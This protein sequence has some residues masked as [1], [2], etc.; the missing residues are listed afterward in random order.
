MSEELQQ[1]V[2]DSLATLLAYVNGPN[3][4]SLKSS[5]KRCASNAFR[6]NNIVSKLRQLRKEWKDSVSA[7]VAAI[8]SIR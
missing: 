6:H 3:A 1:S 2:R 4:I 5:R 8:N 7:I